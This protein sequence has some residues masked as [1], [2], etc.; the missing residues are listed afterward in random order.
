M[1]IITLQFL[2][3]AALVLVPL[4]AFSENDGTG[5]EDPDS[6][7]MER[8]E[9]P[10]N[11]ETGFLDLLPFFGNK[12]QI[13]K[14]KLQPPDAAESKPA[15][16]DEDLNELKA[17]V[18]HWLLTSEITEPAVRKTEDG[19]HYRDYVVFGDEYRID[20]VKGASREEPYL[21]NVYVR[22]DYFQT[23]THDS[24]ERAQ[25][26]YSFKYQPL[27]FRVIF[28]HVEKWDYSSNSEEAPIIFREQW[29]FRKLQSKASATTSEE[30]TTAPGIGGPAAAPAGAV[31]VQKNAETPQ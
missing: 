12:K 26:D 25:S 20:V 9:Q 22:G 23:Q 15:I 18:G 7:Y 4:A 30:A 19:S 14:E 1:K 27:D 3:I 31:D 13:P 24:V 28:A 17:V 16:S 6:A 11:E 10:K 5:G 8:E 29:V 2:A 21:A